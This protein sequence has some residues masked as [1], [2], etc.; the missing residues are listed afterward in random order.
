[1]ADQRQRKTVNIIRRNHHKAGTRPNTTNGGLIKHALIT[2]YQRGELRREAVDLIF[3][4][5]RQARIIEFTAGAKNRTARFYFPLET[6]DTEV[7]SLVSEWFAQL[8][9][10]DPRVTV[11]ILEF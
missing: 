5:Q 10:H 6:G 4:G 9:S 3:S 2:Y 7:V 8:H 1:M 11:Q